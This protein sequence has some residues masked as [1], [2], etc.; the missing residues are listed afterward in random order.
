VGFYPLKSR[1]QFSAKYTFSIQL[2]DIVVL[3]TGL[4]FSNQ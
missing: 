4:R 3:V 1:C 2:E